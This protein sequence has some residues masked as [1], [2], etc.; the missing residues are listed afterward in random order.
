MQSIKLSSR[1]QY[2]WLQ[3]FTDFAL[4]KFKPRYFSIIDEDDPEDNTKDYCI[5]Y[6]LAGK[7]YRFV[8]ELD[9][10]INREDAI[11]L[12]NMNQ[13]KE[14]KKLI[15]DAW[16][17]NVGFNLMPFKKL[18]MFQLDLGVEDTECY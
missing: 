11:D 14:L 4:M 1:L 16:N 13:F 9:L 5:D 18:E 2:T 7:S 8:E 12:D 15:L 6:F 10:C 3:H 17:W